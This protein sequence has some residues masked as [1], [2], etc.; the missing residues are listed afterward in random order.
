MPRDNSV[1]KNAV[2][3][4]VVTTVLVEHTPSANWVRAFGLI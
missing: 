2:I 3:Y 4:A 1:N